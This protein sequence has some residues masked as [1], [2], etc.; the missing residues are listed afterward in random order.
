MTSS[1]REKRITRGC[2]NQIIVT[3][4]TAVTDFYPLC[5]WGVKPTGVTVAKYRMR[6]IMLSP[7]CADGA[8]CFR[9]Q[10]GPSLRHPDAAFSKQLAQIAVL[11][12]WRQRHFEPAQCLG[13]TEQEP[14]IV[15]VKNVLNDR[16]P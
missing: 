5:C 1:V 10:L 14:P 7:S 6:I 13:L 12:S 15:S 2:K 9:S 3:F 4:N 8:C 11:T 16:K